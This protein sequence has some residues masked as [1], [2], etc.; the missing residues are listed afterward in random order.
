MYDK[1]NK[2]IMKGVWFVKNLYKK[3]NEW[4]GY[5]WNVYR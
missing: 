1:K 5:G 4:D 2:K 3:A